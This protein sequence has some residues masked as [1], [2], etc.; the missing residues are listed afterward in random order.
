LSITRA[1]GQPKIYEKMRSK[2]NPGQPRMT[3]LDNAAADGFNL[4]EANMK[5]SQATTRQA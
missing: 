5:Q 3:R 4:L 2:T 1:G